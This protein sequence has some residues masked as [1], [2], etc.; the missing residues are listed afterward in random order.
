MAIFQK[1]LEGLTNDETYFA[2]VF[3]VNHKDRINNRIDLPFA[4]ATPFAYPALSTMPQG[5]IVLVNEDG[6]P[7]E[8]VLL[9]HDYEA[10]LNGA[11]RS[12]LIRKESAGKTKWD[13]GLNTWA[14]SMLKATLDSH[15]MKYDSD[16]Q[17]AIQ[18]TR[19]EMTPTYSVNTVSIMNIPVFLLSANE[20]WSSQNV[21]A[22]K[23]GEYIEGAKQYAH[24]ITWLRSIV[25]SGWSNAVMISSSG[26]AYATN[27]S[28]DRDYQPCIAPM[29]AYAKPNGDGRY[30]LVVK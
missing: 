19:I 14:D 2:K 11:G 27:I 28:Q 4:S 20:L 18:D 24:N 5:T 29:N 3:T 30:I 15:M 1:R 21:G 22:N 12:L 13:D 17:A 25:P 26:T 6:T 8:Y 23:E 10:D 16:V 7:V 9:K